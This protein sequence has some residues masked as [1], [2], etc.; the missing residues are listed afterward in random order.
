MSQ[1]SITQRK[2]LKIR[3]NDLQKVAEVL[4]TEN[5]S[6]ASVGVVSPAAAEQPDVP[7]SVDAEQTKPTWSEADETN[8]RTLMARRKAAGY[9]NRGRDVSDQLVKV[10]D[11]RPNP[12]TIAAT[13]VGLVE[14][15]GTVSRAELLKLITETTFP[16]PKAKPQDQGW[17]QG[18]VAGAIRNGFLMVVGQAPESSSETC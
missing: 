16:Q 18:Y 9:Q 3:S 5:E 4:A 12:G 6:S 15:K 7:V 1:K 13:I 17:C 2:V 14:Q 11:V 10:S 8:L